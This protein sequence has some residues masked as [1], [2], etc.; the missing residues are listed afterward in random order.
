MKLENLYHTKDIRILN[1]YLSKLQKLLH[2]KKL[3][4]EGKR[5]VVTTE[6]IDDDDDDDD[7][8]KISKGNKDE[9]INKAKAIGN[10]EDPSWMKQV[11]NGLKQTGVQGVTHINDDD[12]P[13]TNKEIRSLIELLISLIGGSQSQNAP[14]QNK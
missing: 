8:V 10:F 5:V 2:S 9:F 14:N 4:N 3:L 7:G 6:I 1:E 12:R 13:I 11:I